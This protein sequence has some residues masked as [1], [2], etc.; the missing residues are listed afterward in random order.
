MKKKKRSRWWWRKWFN[1]CSHMYSKKERRM[2]QSTDYRRW[3]IDVTKFCVEQDKK[4]SAMWTKIF[5]VVAGTLASLLFLPLSV[6]RTVIVEYSMQY[7]IAWRN[8]LRLFYFIPFARF[9]IYEICW[10]KRRCSS[11]VHVYFFCVLL[12]LQNALFT[13]CWFQ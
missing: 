8:N 13:K 6:C 11:F 4:K 12:T 7:T 5:D 10:T 3:H 9:P 1:L 2:V